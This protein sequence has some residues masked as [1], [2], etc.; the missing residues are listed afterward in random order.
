MIVWHLLFLDLIIQVETK[1]SLQSLLGYSANPD[2]LWLCRLEME[3]S[4]RDHPH[5]WTKNGKVIVFY[6]R[7]RV[8]TGNPTR[9]V[10]VQRSKME[11]LVMYRRTTKFENGNPSRIT[12]FQESGTQSKNLPW[13]TV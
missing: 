10:T 12:A 11:I 13:I 2:R 6:Y 5:P 4:I 9:I 3:E 7:P 1:R 8:E